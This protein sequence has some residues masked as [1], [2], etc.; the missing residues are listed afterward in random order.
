MQI[1][2]IARSD[3]MGSLKLLASG[4]RS[5]ASLEHDQLMRGCLRR[6]ACES[7]RIIGISSLSS[8]IARW[9]EAFQF[10]SA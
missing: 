8:N 4:R 5:G 10:V 6:E 7:W 3:A 2:Q 9:I 1:I